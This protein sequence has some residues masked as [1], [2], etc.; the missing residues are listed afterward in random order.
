MAEKPGWQCATPVQW[1]RIS[2]AQ[3]E[4][5]CL[6][7]LVLGSQRA[8]TL[9]PLNPFIWTQFLLPTDSFLSLLLIQAWMFLYIRL[10]VSLF[11]LIGQFSAD[12]MPGIYYVWDTS[13]AYVLCSRTCL[14]NLA[15]LG[16]DVISGKPTYSGRLHWILPPP[17]P[18]PPPPS[19]SLSICCFNLFLAKLICTHFIAVPIFRCPSCK[20]SQSINMYWQLPLCN[21]DKWKTKQ[22]NRTCTQALGKLY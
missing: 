9:R 13:A 12:V 10:G 20:L 3:G 15:V 17:P 18:L 7:S 1:H 14:V 5:G 11:S 6:L 21:S 16:N 22:Q 19:S 8:S 2:L 4:S